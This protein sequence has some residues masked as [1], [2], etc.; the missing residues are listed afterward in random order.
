MIHVG[1]PTEKSIRIWVSISAA[2][3]TSTA[4]AA[5]A[6]SCCCCNVGSSCSFRTNFCAGFCSYFCTGIA[7]STTCAP[8]LASVSAPGTAA[9]ASAIAAS[10]LLLHQ[11]PWLYVTRIT[12]KVTQLL[13]LVGITIRLCFSSNNM[14]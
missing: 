3:V 10:A 4:P 1:K 12:I 5:P 14:M 6:N 13:G 8:T 9:P 11:H 7:S 2:A